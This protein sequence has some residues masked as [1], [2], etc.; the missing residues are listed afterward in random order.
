MEEVESEKNDLKLKFNSQEDKMVL[1]NKQLERSEKLKTEYK[2]HFESS[3]DD[4]RS[5]D[6]R[7]KGRVLDLERK[8]NTLEEKISYLLE[9]LNSSKQESFEWK[10]KFEETLCKKK[11]DD[12]MATPKIDILKSLS[13]ATQLRVVAGNEKA[14]SAQKTAI[15][16]KNRYDIAIGEA[17]AALERA[18]T[19]QECSN[20]QVLE[21]EDS[22]REEFSS[23]LAEKVSLSLPPL[24]VLLLSI[25]I[26]FSC[27]YL[28]EIMAGKGN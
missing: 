24:V 22:V 6:D 11:I 17:E 18:T 23:N 5:I 7:Y 3:I 1:L 25:M 8:C 20:K 2:K 26:F 4:M 12:E 15:E 14:H 13:K 10:M 9:M 16:W 19:V 27:N 21:R 28:I